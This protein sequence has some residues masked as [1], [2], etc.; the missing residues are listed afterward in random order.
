MRFFEYE[1]R[2]VVKRAGIPVFFTA[3]EGNQ[4]RRDRGLQADLW[5]P[6]MRDI[7]DHEPA[8]RRNE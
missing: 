1:A 3:Q 4:D 2:E 5:G 8:P 6:G 7:P